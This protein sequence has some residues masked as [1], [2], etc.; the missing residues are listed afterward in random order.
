MSD[1]PRPR[2]V[3][4]SVTACPDGPLLVRGDVELVDDR[5]E[6]LPRRRATLALCRCGA[7][8]I[9]PFCDGT[10]RAIGFRTP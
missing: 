1:A 7:S 8:A 5:G 3:P 2:N 10:H 6:P 4:P 9:K